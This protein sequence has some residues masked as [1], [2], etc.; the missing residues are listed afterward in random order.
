MNAVSQIGCKNVL[1]PAV[2]KHLWIHCSFVSVLPSF[3]KGTILEGKYGLRVSGKNVLSDIP[4][5]LL[6]F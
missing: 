6:K 5:S 1:T 4:P 3:S 2:E